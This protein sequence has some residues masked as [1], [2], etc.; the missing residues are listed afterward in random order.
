MTSRVRAASKIAG[1][2]LKAVKALHELGGRQAH[3]RS[4]V[5]DLPALLRWESGRRGIP[6][7]PVFVPLIL[8]NLH[9]N[10][11]GT[12]FERESHHLTPAQWL[13]LQET[14]LSLHVELDF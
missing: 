11:G 14:F 1:T 12:D 9:A 10:L 5:R 6:N 3:L 8:D 7:Q 4:L 13:L 2:N